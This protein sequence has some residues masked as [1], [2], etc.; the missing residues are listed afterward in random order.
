MSSLKKL[1]SGHGLWFDKD[2][3]IMMRVPDARRIVHNMRRALPPAQKSLTKRRAEA[4]IVELLEACHTHR[5][6]MSRRGPFTDDF[7]QA[8]MSHVQWTR[9]LGLML[10]EEFALEMAEAARLALSPA[11]YARATSGVPLSELNLGNY[12]PMS[13]AALQFFVDIDMFKKRI[14]LSGAKSVRAARGIE[15]TES[16]VRSQP[17]R[18]IPATLLGR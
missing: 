4:K 17:Q 8:V 7:W 5:E 18:C 14:G 12:K 1:A 16:G 13:L 9:G 11:D 6:L 3:P 10:V 2:V 15:I